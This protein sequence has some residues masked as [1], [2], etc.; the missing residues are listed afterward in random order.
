MGN[1]TWGHCDKCE[2]RGYMYGNNGLKRVKRISTGGSSTAFLCS[3]CLREEINWRRQQNQSLGKGMKF[4]VRG[5]KF[6]F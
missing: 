4:R 1:I 2:G 6:G 5:F 3:N